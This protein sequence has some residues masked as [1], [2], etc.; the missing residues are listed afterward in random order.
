M[1]LEQL[2]SFSCRIAKKA[3]TMR[4]KALTKKAIKEFKKQGKEITFENVIK[5]FEGLD[6]LQSVGFT[7]EEIHETIRQEMT[8]CMT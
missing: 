8:K 6:K 7:E 3:A 2:D 5:K 1:T 4:L